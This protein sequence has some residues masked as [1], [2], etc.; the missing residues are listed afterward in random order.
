[1]VKNYFKNGPWYLLILCILCAIIFLKFDLFLLPFFSQ[2]PQKKIEL[3]LTS[4]LEVKKPEEEINFSDLYGGNGQFQVLHSLFDIMKWHQKDQDR[5]CD[6]ELGIQLI[7]GTTS[8][9][10]NSYKALECSSDIQNESHRDQL[11][12]QMLEHFLNNRIQLPLNFITKPPFVN[13]WGKSYAYILNQSD[14]APYNSKEWVNE[15][16]SFF[17]ISELS[18]MLNKYQIQNKA[19]SIISYLTVTEVEEIVRGSPLVLTKDFLLIKNDS[20]FGFSPL[21][22]WVFDSKDFRASLKEDKYELNVMSKDAYCLDNLGNTCLSFNSKHATAYV[23]RY[24]VALLL[25]IGLAMLC[26]LIFSFKYQKEKDQAQQKK[27]LA[28]QVLSHEFRTPVSS[29]LLMIEQLLKRQSQ[30]EIED[31]DLVTRISSEVFRLQRIIEMSRN[32]LQ[33][34]SHKVDFNFQRIPSINN[35]IIEL[36]ESIS[37]HIYCE[38]LEKDQSVMIDTYWVRFI[39]SN[40]IQNAF[41]HGK[42]PVFICLSF[43]KEKLHIRVVDQGDCEFHSLNEMTNAFV[44]SHSSKGMGLGLNIVKLVVEDLGSELQ[45]SNGPTSF[46]LILKKALER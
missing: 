25:F 22:Y 32:Y 46:N 4:Y 29:L 12:N 11:K 36:A 9:T 7:A 18:E 28:L 37:P 16:L 14:L 15:H 31:Q 21:S 13:Q 27:R 6:K 5:A 30:L 35:W 45:F 38:I 41:L 40:L 39:L 42:P 24:A 23:Y 17:K 44:K 8:S 33:A 19:Y 43:I 3:L 34:D 10:K 2:K 26:I 1:M 20:K